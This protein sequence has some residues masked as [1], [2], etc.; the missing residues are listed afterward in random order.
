MA[1]SRFDSTLMPLAARI[2]RAAANSHRA[3]LGDANLHGAVI[4][5]AR[6]TRGSIIERGM[7]A[8][9]DLRAAIDDVAG[10]HLKRAAADRELSRTLRKIG[11]PQLRNAIEV[12][13]DQVL[14]PSEVAHYYA[15]LMAGLAL[16]DLERNRR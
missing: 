9:D 15:G 3:S 8:S 12:A 10:R 14:E 1:R 6:I 2:A 16:I 5:L 13:H 4:E 7:T 11:D